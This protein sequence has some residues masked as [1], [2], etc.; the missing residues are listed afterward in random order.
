MLTRCG[1]AGRCRPQPATCLSLAT[2]HW[3]WRPAF[4]G[5][6]PP[7]CRAWMM[8]RLLRCVVHARPDGRGPSA[9][10]AHE[11]PGGAGC[12][13]STSWLPST[14]DRRR[15][16]APA[17]PMG[18]MD[19]V[20]RSRLRVATD[21]RVGRAEPPA[22]AGRT[23]PAPDPSRTRPA[24]HVTV[25]E[26]RLGQS[27]G[28]ALASRLGRLN[29][30]Q[31]AVREP[32]LPDTAWAYHRLSCCPM[33]GAHPEAHT[34]RIHVNS[35]TTDRHGSIATGIATGHE[36]GTGKRMVCK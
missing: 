26:I 14:T 13:V 16:A 10:A 25:R 21:R 7:A 9:H 27:S 34:L 15:R 18:W 30:E 12:G 1:G 23:S 36:A 29:P 31:Q 35:S 24:E 19:G 6:L 17:C 3:K 5:R 8:R 20:D 32:F 11:A 22:A 2:G 33:H 28:E 4:P